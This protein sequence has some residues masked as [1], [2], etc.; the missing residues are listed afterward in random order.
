MSHSLRDIPMYAAHGHTLVADTQIDAAIAKARM[1]KEPYLRER[2][3]ALLYV[4]R[5]HLHT[6]MVEMKHN[7]IE[8]HK[9]E[10]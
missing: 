10:V 7:I 5:A 9:P 6:A 4:A 3:L 1:V 2:V 8:G